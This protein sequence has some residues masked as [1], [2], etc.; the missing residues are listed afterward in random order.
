[1]PVEKRAY[2]EAVAACPEGDDHQ[3]LEVVGA[4]PEAA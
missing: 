1:M 4:S 2:R 3:T